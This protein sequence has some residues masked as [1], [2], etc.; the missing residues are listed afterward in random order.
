MK[1]LKAKDK[2]FNISLI[3]MFIILIFILIM[4]LGLGAMDLSFTDCAKILF[5]KIFN[6]EILSSFKANEIA[7]IWDIRLPRI[8]TSIFVGMSLSLCGVIFQGVLSNPLADPYTIGVSTGAAFG[9]SLA[10][11]ISL[12]TGIFIPT[13]LSAFLFAVITLIL[14]IFISFKSGG[15]ITS[16]LIISGIILSNIFSSLI[17]FLKI[18]AG[19]NVGAIVFWLMGSFSACSRSDL[20]ILFPVFVIVFLISM[21]YAKDLNIISLGDETAKSLGINPF[22]TRL[23][24]LIAGS[25]LT[26]I[27]VS[28]CGVIGFVGLIVPHLLRFVTSSD[29]KVLIPLSALTGGILL[30]L[31]DN[32]TRVCFVGEVPVGVLT[33]VIGGPFF[34]YVF[35]RKDKNY[36]N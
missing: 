14:V 2:V 15:F 35:L 7:V 27:C 30:C 36:E 22:K 19:E 1:T 23:I 28:I 21:F 18:L 10:I 32:I 11:V 34:I 20:I 17:S 9:A 16:N 13:G 4:S 3:T 5:G 12:F 29:N 6:K 24:Y 31:A 8:L 25:V 26:A 33:T